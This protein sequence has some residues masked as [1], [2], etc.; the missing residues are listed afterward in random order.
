MRTRT[1]ISSD[2]LLIIA[3]IAVIYLIIQYIVY[4]KC[5]KKAGTDGWKAL[6]PVYN[7]YVTAM[8]ATGDSGY[9]YKYVALTLACGLINQLTRVD[10][11]DAYFFLLLLALLSLAV[12]IATLIVSVNVSYK[13]AKAFGRSD[14]FAVARIF[15]PTICTLIMVLDPDTKYCGPVKITDDN[16]FPTPGDNTGTEVSA[17]SAPKASPAPSAVITDSISDNAPKVPD[18]VSEH[19]DTNHPPQEKPKEADWNWFFK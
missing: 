7:K 13:F 1:D 4:Y 12:G 8:I 16:I 3:I 2:I 11:G 10:Y 18:T 9:S 14:G 6:I 19:N 17:P 5:F 15:F